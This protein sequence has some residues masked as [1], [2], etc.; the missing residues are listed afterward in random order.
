MS[1]S[2]SVP[3]NWL[4]HSPSKESDEILILDQAA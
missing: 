4:M 1:D 3:S 2:Y